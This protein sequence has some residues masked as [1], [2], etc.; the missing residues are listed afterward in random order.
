MLADYRF[1][2]YEGSGKHGSGK[3]VFWANR[4]KEFHGTLEAASVRG[5]IVRSHECF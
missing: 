5:R 1:A 2:G 4:R 3:P